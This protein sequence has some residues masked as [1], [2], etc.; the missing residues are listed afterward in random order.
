MM[1]GLFPEQE[2]NQCDNVNLQWVK[3]LTLTNWCGPYIPI[4]GYTM[5]I[6]RYKGLR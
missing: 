2:I 3:N 5:P 6:L 1:I 4:S